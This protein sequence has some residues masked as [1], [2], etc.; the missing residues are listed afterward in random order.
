M[1]ILRFFSGIQNRFPGC[2][3]VL[4]ELRGV[5]SEYEYDHVFFDVNNLLYGN[6]S[7]TPS[8]DEMFSRLFRYLDQVVNYS[9]PT[10]TV[11]MAIDGPGPRAKIL[12][13]RARRVARAKS[14]LDEKELIDPTQVIDNFQFTPGTDFMTKLKESL[15]YYAARRVMLNRNNGFKCYLSGADD[16]GEG[17][18]KIF[19]Y[20]KTIKPK[21]EQQKNDSPFSFLTNNEVT[22]KPKCLVVGND[23]DLI[24][25]SLQQSEY[26]DIDILKIENN[27]THQI[28]SI[29]E[30]RRLLVE[31]VVGTRE[32][33][34]EEKK[35]IIDDFTVISLFS[36]ND[37][38]PKLD[39]YIY[40]KIWE[41]YCAIKNSERF[42]NQYIWKS[43]PKSDGYES[44]LNGSMIKNL[45]KWVNWTTSLEKKLYQE[46]NSGSKLARSIK[47][48]LGEENFSYYLK[49]FEKG[50]YCYVL[51][52]KG[53]DLSFGVSDDL[54]KAQTIADQI[55]LKKLKHLYFNAKA[56]NYDFDKIDDNY[57]DLELACGHDNFKGFYEETPEFRYDPETKEELDLQMELYL[58]GISWIMQ[59]YNANCLDYSYYYPFTEGP[60]AK[61][62]ATSP[63]LEKP[64]SFPKSDSVAINPVDFLFSVCPVDNCK[65]FLPKEFTPYV[66]QNLTLLKDLDT[67]SWRKQFHSILD[68]ISTSVRSFETSVEIT[69]ANCFAPSL[70]FTRATESSKKF[71]SFSPP[72]LPH[73][74]NFSF[75]PDSLLCLATKT[76]NQ[77]GYTS[78]VDTNNPYMLP[79]SKKKSN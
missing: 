36:G 39:P 34:N 45:F 69:N 76:P 21:I 48:F 7:R 43:E 71:F 26:F 73:R 24:L 12:T 65:N 62:L 63:L 37:Y 30:L 28:V 51:K 68:S 22:E 64:I 3:Q 72:A 13:Q 46:H 66:E 58:K 77:R 74:Q 50:R 38:V 75:R 18:L 57:C 35:R 23:S 47:E 10:Q 42:K 9:S 61:T 56:A 2:V 6:I 17:E 32:I 40:L 55:A 59:Y 19:E 1:G 49:S 52:Y 78:F 29:K 5:R 70:M 54:E 33:S 31:D 44:T 27:L 25:F 41:G 16:C 11:F 53:K 4:G 60:L 79:K 8:Q 67:A 15:S 20:L 14:L